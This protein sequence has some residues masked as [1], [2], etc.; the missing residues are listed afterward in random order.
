MGL[1]PMSMQ[2]IIMVLSHEMII[3]WQKDSE[4]NVLS[5]LEMKGATG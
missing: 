4:S 5:K 2:L 1:K 3:Q